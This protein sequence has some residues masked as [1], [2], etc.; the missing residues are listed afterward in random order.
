VRIFVTI[1]LILE[2]TAMVLNGQIPLY[3]N[4]EVDGT[5]RHILFD[6]NAKRVFQDTADFYFNWYKLFMVGKNQNISI[7][8][9]ECNTKIADSISRL[10]ASDEPFMPAEKSGKWAFYRPDGTLLTGYIFQSV[11]AFYRGF[12]IVNYQN[13][14]RFIDTTGKFAEKIPS[15][16]ERD[17]RKWGAQLDLLRVDWPHVLHIPNGKLIESKDNGR[18]GV[19]DINSGKTIVPMEFEKIV[20]CSYNL[21]SVKKNGKYGVFDM[22]KQQLIIDTIYSNIQF[23][24]FSE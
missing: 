11:S 12:A 23:I 20:A 7:W 17:L 21:V 14:I 18:V 3:I 5:H 13:T 24:E 16:V 8:N 4:A 1:L 2:S 6:R 19:A 9:A 22:E 15:V 10:A